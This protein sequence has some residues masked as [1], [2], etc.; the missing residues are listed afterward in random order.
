VGRNQVLTIVRTATIVLTLAAIGFAIYET[1]RLGTFNPTRFFAYFT[2]QS[3]L[4]VVILYAWLVARRDRPRGR[5]LESFRGATTTY[6][7]VVFLVVI[8]LLQGADVGLRLAWVDV[9]LHKVVPVVVVLDW[10]VDRPTVRLGARDALA[11]TVY[12][13]VWAGLTLVRG[14]ADDWYPYPFLDPANGGYGTVAVMVVAITVAF[15]AIAGAWI[16]IGN[17]RAGA[18]AAEVHPA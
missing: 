5:S 3:N 15:L 4:I 12:P 8:F 13:L 18:A 17:R 2:I 7:T 14:A 16:W 10:L 1:A 6:M 11:W 9:V